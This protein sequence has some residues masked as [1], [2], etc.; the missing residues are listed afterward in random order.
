MDQ[1]QQAGRQVEELT[2]ALNGNAG[3]VGPASL[4]ASTLPKGSVEPRGSLPWIKASKLVDKSK[5]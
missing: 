4:A 3:L 2:R 5:N 1:G